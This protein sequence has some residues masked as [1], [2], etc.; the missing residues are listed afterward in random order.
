MVNSLGLVAGAPAQP[1]LWRRGVED[2]VSIDI[3]RRLS[4]TFAADVL[5]EVV[6]GPTAGIIPVLAWDGDV[7]GT[8]AQTRRY[9]QTPLTD[10]CQTKMNRGLCRAEPLSSRYV[11]LRYHCIFYW[12]PPKLDRLPTGVIPNVDDKIRNRV[13]IVRACCTHR[14]CVRK[15]GHVRHGGADRTYFYGAAYG[16]VVVRSAHETEKDEAFEDDAVKQRFIAA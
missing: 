15:P 5:A 1:Q 4:L 16:R 9:G 13:F 14:P 7:T 6:D 11:S 3:E 2:R 8:N 12:H 10:Q